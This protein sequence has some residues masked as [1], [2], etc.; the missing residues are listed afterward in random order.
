MVLYISWCRKGRCKTGKIEAVSEG[1]ANIRVVVTGENLES[2]TALITVEVDDRALY[3]V[4]G[5]ES[6]E[7]YGNQKRMWNQDNTLSVVLGGWMFPNNGTPDSNILR[8]ETLSNGEHYQWDKTS[9]KAK[10]K[11]TG[12]DYYV[13][14]NNNK[15]ARQENG[16]NAMPETTTIG[17]AD[18]KNTQ[19]RLRIQCSM[20]LALVHSWCLILKPTVR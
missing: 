4:K 6:S 16:S 19:P 20:F 9:S 17:T 13:T 14:C 11:L 2:T 18:F 15:N 12:F 1:T 10:W 3:R 7:T 5:P 8:N